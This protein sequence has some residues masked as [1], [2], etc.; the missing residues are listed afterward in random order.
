MDSTQKVLH[1]FI[2]LLIFGSIFL[3]YAAPS[4]GF[5]IDTLK[6]IQGL[7][8]KADSFEYIMDNMVAY[9]NIFIR[10]G[11]I[12]FYA[13]R[14]IVNNTNKNIEISGNVRFFNMVR[15]RQ[16]ME[17]WEVRKLEKDP[18]VKI[19]VVG[20]VMTST[21]RQKLVVD[22]IREV[23]TWHGDR[24]IGNLITGVFEFGT[25]QANLGGWTV[26]GDK[27][28]RKADGEIVVKDA[29]VSPCPSYLEGHSVYSLTS[30]KVTAFPSRGDV[31]S[32]RITQLNSNAA[33][34]NNYHFWAYNNVLYIG[35]MPV[36]W[37]PI[38]YKPPPNRMGYWTVTAGSSSAYGFYMQTSNNWDLWDTPDLKIS[39]SNLLDYY[40]NR[41][42]GYGNASEITTPNSVTQSFLYGINDSN[43]RYSAPNTSRYSPFSPYIYDIDLRNFTHLTD[44]LDF[45]GRFAQISDIYFLYDYFGNLASIDPAPP[46]YANLDYQLD[47]AALS[48]NIRPQ[49]YTWYTTTQELPKLQLT[50]PRQELFANIYYQG[51]T[52][53]SYLSQK[54]TQLNQSRPGGLPNPA[55]YNSWRFDTV[56]FAYYP[57]QMDVFNLIPRAGFRLTGYSNSSNTAVSDSDL[58]NM[59]AVS[60][61]E[62]TAT[63]TFNNYDTKG[64]STARFIPEFGMTLNTKT[65]QSWE[66]VKNAYWNMDGLRHVATPYIDYT[67]LTPSQKRDHILYFD[68]IDR[69]DTQNFVRI[70]IDNR[71]R[72]RRGGWKSSQAYTWAQMHNYLDFLFNADSRKNETSGTIKNLGD[73]GNIITVT[74]TENLNLNAQILV[75]A[76]QMIGSNF[77][78]CLASS[79]VGGTWNFAD[80]WGFTGSYYYSANNN[81]N[82]TY[83]MGSMEQQVQSGTFFRRMYQKSS[84]LNTGLNFKINDRTKGSFN[85]QYDF[86]NN[87]YPTAGVTITRDLPCNLQLIL[88]ANTSQRINNNNNG[89]YTN[90][91]ASASLQFTATPSYEITPMTSLLPNDITQE[92]YAY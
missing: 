10:K 6:A 28:T 44:R 30:S 80:G 36:F 41:G 69:I 21:G 62:S 79:N 92:P 60:Q 85:I 3:L 24:A 77:G 71:L 12:I 2:V 49:T 63:A 23:L 83:S 66:G 68:D 56:N 48:A 53:A 65:S 52:Q 26:V 72:T 59:I 17:Y 1:F 81:T 58:N 13:D 51:Q 88:N 27:A 42:F 11:D 87:M 22:T 84:Y 82:P 19:K 38:M 15:S 70:G 46:T 14:A 25:F 67:Y 18:N 40:N 20:T 7:N 5:D 34:L 31:S 9:G 32:D 75:D 91:S 4:L 47:W 33:S 78:T 61:P 8:A 64:G 35:N 76:G 54:W 55:N 90:T 39:T 29:T 86:F 50:I 57:I 37:L 73:F 45:R 16:E 89:T 43:P 74:P